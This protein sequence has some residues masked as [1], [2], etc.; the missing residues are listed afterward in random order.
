MVT[1]TKTSAMQ[2]W[3]TWCNVCNMFLDFESF[4]TFSDFSLNFDQMRKLNKSFIHLG[5]A[6]KSREI[7]LNTENGNDWIMNDRRKKKSNSNI[8]K[9]PVY[10][11][12]FWNKCIIPIKEKRI[13]GKQLV[14]A[15]TVIIGER[16][17][18]L[19]FGKSLKIKIMVNN[20]Q[21]S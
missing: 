14:F 5:I 15:F 1:V 6:R 17:P 19:H 7:A 2:Q 13:Y 21:Y 12:D 3:Q 8:V 11:Q 16:W 10:R 20:Q 9:Y 4:D 18:V